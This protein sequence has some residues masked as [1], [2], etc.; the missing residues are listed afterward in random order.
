M[1]RIA[2]FAYGV[3]CYAMFF[4]V[5]VY[6]IGFLGNFGV[7]NSLD[8]QPKS[9]WK[10]A[11]AIDCLLLAGFAVQHSGMARPGFKRWWT[12]FV[13][14]PIERST[15]VLFS[16]VA[17]IALFY[18]W[19]PIGGT[20]WNI[21]SAGFRGAIYAVYA[22]GWLTVLYATCLLNHFELFGL[23]QVTLYAMGKHHTPI[24]FNEPGLYRYV[25]HPL[26]VGWLTVFWFTPTMTVAHMLFAMM[27]T[28]Y[29]LIAIQLEESDLKAAL[30]E[31][32][33]YQVRVPMLV[34]SLK[35]VRMQMPS[36]R[37][38]NA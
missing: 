31:Y 24:S 38:A 10:W 12:R 29:I 36:K 32:A 21:E 8:A 7:Q 4:G 19:E 11:V 6:S 15:Y 18:F 28:G 14:E 3:C 20:I 25:R 1:K 26:Y 5:F 23:R 16:N 35:P 17:M 34:P 37:E 27:C 13:P 2:V 9:D 33:D 30:P 22:I